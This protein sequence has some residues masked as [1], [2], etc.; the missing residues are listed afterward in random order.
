MPDSIWIKENWV[1][2]SLMS[3]F[4]NVYVRLELWA[5]I[6]DTTTAVEGR[7]NSISRFLLANRKCFDKETDGDIHISSSFWCAE[8]PHQERV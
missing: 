2:R 8:L 6:F 4:Q 3:Y 5:E 1:E 7:P